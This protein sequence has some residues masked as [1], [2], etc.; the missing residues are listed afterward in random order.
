MGTDMVVNRKLEDGG[1]WH[2]AG[3]LFHLGPQSMKWCDHVK[4]ESLPLTYPS[5]DVASQ[6]SD[7][8][9]LAVQ[10]KQHRRYDLVTFHFREQ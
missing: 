10:I 4:G 6:V 1:S 3:L 7:R 2:S 5:L 9:E 8:G